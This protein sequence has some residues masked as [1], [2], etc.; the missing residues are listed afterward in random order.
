MVYSSP[1]PV[2][3]SSFE[4]AP[5]EPVAPARP[6]AALGQLPAHV[7]AA[8]WHGDELGTAVTSVVSSGHPALDR[9]LPGGG[10]PCN[11]LLEVLCPQPSMLDWRLLGPA[12]RTVV[13]SGRQVVVVAP[14]RS[15]HLAG[16][17]HEG[18]GAQHLIWL[19]AGSLA[20]RFWCAEQFGLV[21]AAGAVPAWLPQER[22]EQLS[23]REA[24]RV[25]RRSMAMGGPV[26]QNKECPKRLLPPAVRVRHGRPHE[27]SKRNLLKVVAPTRG[28]D[29]SNP[30]NEIHDKPLR[31]IAG[32]ETILRFRMQF[33]A[34]AFAALEILSGNEVDRVYCD[35][36]EDFVV[37]RT[38]RKG[39]TYHF[40]QVK[41]KGKLNKQWTRLEVFALKKRRGKSEVEDAERLKAMRDSIAGKLFAHT[42]E[43]GENCHAVTIL[44]NVHFDDDVL[45]AIDD[46]RAGTS[47]DTHVREFIEHFRGAFAGDVEWT[48]EQLH[49]ARGK[50]TVEPGAQHIGESLE[51]FTSSARDA[52]WKY[53]EIDL[54]PHE[55]DEIAHSLVALITSRSC[56]RIAGMTRANLDEAVSV[57]LKDLLQVLSISTP[58]YETLS[59]GDDP[60]TIK[61]ASILQRQL[62]LAGASEAAIETASRMKV[63]WDVWLRTNRHVFT[64][65]ALETLWQE[66]EDA[67]KNWLMAG[68]RLADLRQLIS[69]MRPQPWAKD[70]PSLTDDLLFGAVM[71]AIVRRGAR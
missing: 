1:T 11:S 68:G 71:S 14:P 13:A 65:M 24:Q 36:H 18:P 67:C 39:S 54:R 22:Q 61:A 7:R 23:R 28:K 17:H 33:Q 10:W 30:M 45:K 9:E 34:A 57:E 8:L 35:Y 16:L 32:R 2:R 48:N 31:E 26:Y 3:V 49:A 20:G 66:V 5:P 4:E 50:L 64:E 44:S 6:A 63:E 56:T 53:S 40:F 38:T 37:R 62:K 60:K 70:F 46:I 43:F 25:A 27:I 55:V 52:I 29:S 15:P 42:I 41:T 21:N 19:R 51:R 12:L 47:A 58:V 69:D 59:K